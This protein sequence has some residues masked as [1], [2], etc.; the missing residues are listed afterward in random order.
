[1]P[2]AEPGERRP[3]GPPRTRA[4]CRGRGPPCRSPRRR[5][6]STSCASR[7]TAAVTAL[8]RFLARSSL[9]RSSPSS[10]SSKARSRS[11]VRGISNAGD[12]EEPD[13]AADRPVDRHHDLRRE[14]AVVARPAPGRVG[15]VVAE[16]VAGA[17]LGAAQPERGARVLGVHE[18]QPVRH[19]RP[20]A[21][22]AEVGVLVPHLDP[23]VRAALHQRPAEPVP[24]EP[25]VVQDRRAVAEQLRSRSAEFVVRATIRYSQ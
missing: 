19:H 2:N 24:D 22:P 5:R 1:M 14:Q 23:E 25:Q 11:T 17:H 20:A 8:C 7:N 4:R 16:E 18:R 10:R 12:P 9:R 6:A 21:D 3:P 15:D 13:V